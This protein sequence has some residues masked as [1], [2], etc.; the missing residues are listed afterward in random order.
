MNGF[1]ST[2]I[3][4]IPFSGIQFPIWEFLKVILGSMHDDKCCSSF[5]SAVAGSL[6]GAFAA[7]VTTPFDVVKTRLML[8][9]DQ[10]G[11]PYSGIIS[12]FRRVIQTEGI[13]ALYK[14]IGPRTMWIGIGG[15]VYFGVYS[16]VRNFNA[17]YEGE[18]SRCI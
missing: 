3:R 2:V 13:R 10:H 16:K 18:A 1:G 17:K 7:A 5:E 12:T 11:V 9:V 15:F 14:G 6:A 4:E 8:R